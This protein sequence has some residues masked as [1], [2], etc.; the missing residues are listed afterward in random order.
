M[1]A[2]RYSVLGL[3]LLALYLTT[4]CSGSIF[5][6]DESKVGDFLQP[7]STVE[8]MSSCAVPGRCTLT[9]NVSDA[10]ALEPLRCQGF[11]LGK[12]SEGFSKP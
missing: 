9:G 4:A 11:E 8:I 5:G 1:A 3:S 7:L 12:P 2:S 10:R 6:K